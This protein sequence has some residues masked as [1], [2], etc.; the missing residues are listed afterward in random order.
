MESNQ[1]HSLHPDEEDD[2]EEVMWRAERD[3]DAWVE[4][5]KVFHKPAY[6]KGNNEMVKIVNQKCVKSFENPSVFAFRQCGN[7]CICE[8]CYENKGDIDMWKSII[9]RT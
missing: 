2:Q 8:K 4:E 1:N 3:L 5:Q 9:C 7:Q 6:Y